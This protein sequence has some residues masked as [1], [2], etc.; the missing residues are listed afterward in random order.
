MKLYAYCILAIMLGTSVPSIHAA[1][2]VPIIDSSESSSQQSYSSRQR[3]VQASNSLSQSTSTSPAGLLYQVELL[4]Q[5]VQNLRGMLEEQAH[6]ISQMREEQRD[7]YLDLDRRLS[8]LN[9]PGK[10]TTESSFSANPIGQNPGNG[11]LTSGGDEKG[12]YQAAFDL[13]RN[14]QYD[15]AITAFGQFVRDF[16]EGEY[17]GNAYYWLG[18]VQVVKANYQAALIAFDTLLNKFP[19]HRKT[20]DAKYKLG[21]VYREMGN[22]VKAKQLLEEVVNQY[23]GSS[24]AKLSEAELRNLSP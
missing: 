21:K 22:Q 12:A 6:Q 24:A 18:E 1:P 9:Q 15:D 7:R 4:Q 2:A 10:V 14:K 5:E 3:Q 17:T 11:G 19:Q 13:I 8:L 20:A 16:P 23:P